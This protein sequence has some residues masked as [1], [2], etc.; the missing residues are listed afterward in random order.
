MH[1]EHI[2]ACFKYFAFHIHESFLARSV[3]QFCEVK[4]SSKLSVLN[5]IPNYWQKYWEVL[6]L[7]T[8]FT[9]FSAGTLQ[10]LFFLQE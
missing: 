10:Q 9:L 6:P 1:T 4:T 8:D 5:W 2:F 3:L 7:S